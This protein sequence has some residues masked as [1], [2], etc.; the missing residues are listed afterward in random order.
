MMH[1]RHAR[2]DE[3]LDPNQGPYEIDPAPLLG[4]WINTNT[5]TTGIARVLI[6]RDRDGV[7][8]SIWSADAPNAAAQHLARSDAVY[9]SGPSATA[10]M[11]LSARYED[12]SMDTTLEAN[13]SLGLLVIATRHTF[14]NDERRSNYFSREFFHYTGETA[15]A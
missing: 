15:I 14:K 6:S 7:S 5:A 2:R 1:V 3:Q 4:Y 13:L 11:A 12:G 10:A 9:A 8:I